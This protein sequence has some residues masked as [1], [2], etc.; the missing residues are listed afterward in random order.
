LITRYSTND[1][2]RLFN[3]F[4]GSGQDSFA[5]PI[6]LWEEEGL[7]TVRASVP[8]VQ[9]Q[10]LK[11]TIEDNVLTLSGESKKT[12]T[13]EGA[14]VYRMETAYGTFSR[15][16]RRHGKDDTDKVEASFE[17]GVVTVTLPRNTADQKKV[18]DIKIPSNGTVAENN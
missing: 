3:G 2:N 17:N 5:M 14:K 15:S 16:V 7:L 13:L 9:P 1:F 11:I 18:I 12:E 6:D 10:D 4:Y 8:G